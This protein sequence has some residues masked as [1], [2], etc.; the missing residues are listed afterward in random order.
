MIY[1]RNQWNRPRVI[2]WQSLDLDLDLTLKI[3]IESNHIIS[4]VVLPSYYRLARGTDRENAFTEAISMCKDFGVEPVL[5]RWL[6]PNSVST[7]KLR[8]ELLTEAHVIEVMTAL[9][10]EADDYGVRCTAID[11]EGYEGSAFY[12]SAG[13][14]TRAEAVRLNAACEIVPMKRLEADFSL[15]AGEITDPYHI[16]N[17]ASQLGDLT[18][19]EHTYQGNRKVYDEASYDIFGAWLHDDWFDPQR[20][21]K[22]AG[23]YGEQ[24]G[25]GDVFL[26]VSRSD[27]AKYAAEIADI[28]FV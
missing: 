23:Q 1:C 24:L 3:A 12:K 20:A 14:L 15:P 5:S 28:G 17:I 7:S 6:W 21:I 13:G 11:I 18:I 16:Y 22:E 10:D 9:R 4:H 8:S 2:W 27:T 25:V 19:A 26:Y